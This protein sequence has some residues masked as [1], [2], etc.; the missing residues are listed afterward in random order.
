MRL[1]DLEAEFVATTEQ[2]YQRVETFAEAQGV[3]HLCP[4]CFAENGGDVGTHWCISWFAGRNTP[5]TAVPS[6][7]WQASGSSL[8]D[9]T[10]AP[11]I[12]IVGG[13]N[14]H[15]YIQNGAIVNA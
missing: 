13:C 11:S 12:Q 7:R 4:K 6:P 15:G 10:L 5:S 1:V 14:W 8:E 3:A 2:G 9:L